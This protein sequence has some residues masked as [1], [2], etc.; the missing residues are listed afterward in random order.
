MFSA[1]PSCG[2]DEE[3]RFFVSLGSITEPRPKLAKPSHRSELNQTHQSAILESWRSFAH[4]SPQCAV[5][6]RHRPRS[7][8]M[9]MLEASRKNRRRERGL[10]SRCVWADW[11]NMTVFFFHWDDFPTVT[12]YQLSF[13]LGLRNNLCRHLQMSRLKYPRSGDSV[14]DI[15]LESY[16]EQ[17]WHWPQS[18]HIVSQ[19]ERTRHN[20]HVNNFTT[21]VFCKKNFG[22]CIT[23]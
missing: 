7:Y 12:L 4:V 9:R 22:R 8:D 13:S 15:G 2:I 3:L 14:L 23:N 11:S 21:S 1:W 6:K 16:L 19:T 5:H 20:W 10:K 17:N 18:K